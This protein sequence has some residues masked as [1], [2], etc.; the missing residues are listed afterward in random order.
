[1]PDVVVLGSLNLDLVAEVASLPRPGETVHAGALREECG[2]KGANQAV[3]AA[4]LGSRVALVG[5]VG[6]DDVGQRLREQLAAESVDVSAVR[7]V[8]GRSGTALIFVAANSENVIA[9]A[10]GAN[11]D[12]GTLDAQTAADLVGPGD[13]L[14]CQ[15]EVPV[16]AVE[17]A[18]RAAKLRGATVVLNAA[19]AGPLG[20]RL[21]AVID[22][23]VVNE[24]EA[25]VLLGVSPAA[26]P[27]AAEA[28]AKLVGM[29]PQAVVITMGERGAVVA[30]HFGTTRIVPFP[31]DALDSV[32][33]GDAFVGA[34]AA[35]LAAGVDLL[36]AARTGAAAGALTTLCAGA[37]AAMPHRG[38]VERLLR[39]VE[40]S[41]DRGSRSAS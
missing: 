13:V 26:W 41:I 12:I 20:H 6:E 15:L 39:G 1:M 33:A 22:V 29:G 11:F 9:V 5:A 23:L 25:A 32:G 7:R 18:A 37:Q 35:K 31:V 8:S 36:T 16:V 40:Q 4:R 28:S 21:L 38:A 10:A 14:L 34:L 2:G 24:T 30:D 27:W 19:P 17:F 3:A